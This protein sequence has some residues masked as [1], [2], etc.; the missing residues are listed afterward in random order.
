VLGHAGPTV[1]FSMSAAIAAILGA[2]IG[3]G[4]TLL[5]QLLGFRSERQRLEQERRARDLDLARLAFA[6][7][8]KAAKQVEH[9]AE[10]RQIFPQNAPHD[11]TVTEAT[12]AL[13][14]SVEEVMIYASQELAAEAKRYVR[15]LQEA[16]WRPPPVPLHMHLDVQRER[17][18]GQAR[19]S[20][21]W[22]TEQNQGHQGAPEGRPKLPSEE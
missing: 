2:A 8:L 15:L 22:S 21:T 11:L 9:L 18:L 10:Q 1:P 19:R 16:A 4:A 13:W 12:S 20:L 7:F 17:L 3:A 6:N 5:S 14:V